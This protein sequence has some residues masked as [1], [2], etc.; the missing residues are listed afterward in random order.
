M[1]RTRNRQ[2]DVN[3]FF[4]IMR[5]KRSRDSHGFA[6]PF[7]SRWNAHYR[8]P[9]HPAPTP[10]RLRPR[11]QTFRYGLVLGVRENL[12]A[13]LAQAMAQGQLAIQ[14][15]ELAA[16]IVIGIRPN[17][18][19]FRA[20]GAK[21]WTLQLDFQYIW[22]PGGN[23]TDENG[24]VVENAAVV[25]ARTTLNFWSGGRGED[26]HLDSRGQVCLRHQIEQ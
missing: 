6:R 24:R 1:S 3:G 4:G 21:G 25:G 10:L 20:L 8:K 15:V 7:L 2:F 26:D 17:R 5:A 23:V 19:L 18:R 14:D 22:Q 16:D 13:D 11:R 9:V 12:K